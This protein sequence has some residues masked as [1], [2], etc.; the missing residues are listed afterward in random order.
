M[1]LAI[2]GEIID[3]REENSLRF[4][5]V[6]FGGIT[7]EVCLSYVPEAKVG[8]YVIVHAG[9]AINTV[10]EAEAKATLELAGDLV[11]EVP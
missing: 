1:C 11:D 2:P 3:I 10:N 8:D 7:R 9:F 4:G 5:K 6:R